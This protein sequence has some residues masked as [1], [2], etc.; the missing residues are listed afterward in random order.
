LFL[1]FGILR[2]TIRSLIAKDD[3]EKR[4]IVEAEEQSRVAALLAAGFVLDD[5]GKPLALTE[6]DQDKMAELL[7]S[8]DEPKTYQS[9]L[10][11]LKRLVDDDPKIVAQVL[12]LWIKKDE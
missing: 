4:A 7:A 6:D 5:N 11:Y 9:R 2:P 3:D 1:I 12:K 10:D 8:L